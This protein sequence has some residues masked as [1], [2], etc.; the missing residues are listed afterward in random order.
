M[1]SVISVDR[2]EEHMIEDTLTSKT[3]TSVVD[4]AVEEEGAQATEG[5]IKPTVKKVRPN[6]LQT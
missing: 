3:P 5:T 2:G 6:I 1:M 4:M